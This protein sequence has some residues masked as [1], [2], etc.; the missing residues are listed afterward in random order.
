MAGVAV[1]WVFGILTPQEM[2]S[3]V[4]MNAIGLLFGTMIIAGALS[5]AHFFQ[6][7]GISIANACRRHPTYLLVV[8]TLMTGGLSALLPNVTTVLF[9]VTITI[10]IAELLKLNP[11]PHILSEIL[12]S[13]I[14]RVATLIGDP[15]NIM[16]ATATG[17]P[18]LEF[19]ANLGSGAY[20]I[21]QS[22]TDQLTSAHAERRGGAQ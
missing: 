5:E 18:F 9:M 19:L 3:Y 16:I 21:F 7:V 4:D 2:I 17:F 6:W 10:Q 13:N 11:K 15:P 20:R 1:M 12:A 8:F 22:D 14:G